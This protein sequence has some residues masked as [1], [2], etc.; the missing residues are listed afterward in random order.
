MEPGYTLNLI[1]LGSNTITGM[2]NMKSG[3]AGIFVQTGAT[4][5][6]YEDE[7]RG[8]LTVTGGKRG[9]AIGSVYNSVPGI[10]NIYGGTI[11][12]QGGVDGGAGIGSGRSCSGNKINIYG[13]N[14][15][16]FGGFSAAGIGSGYGTSGG[17]EGKVGDYNG[18]IINITG[19]TV[20][21]CSSKL[22]EGLSLDAFDAD[23]PDSWAAIFQSNGFSAGIGGGYG[24]SSGVITIG[25]D[26][27]VLAIG[28]CGGAG[29]GAGRGTNK[30]KN[31]SENCTPFNITIRDNAWVTAY[32]PGEYR[33]SISPGSGAGIGAGR[34]WNDG[35]SIVIE[36]TPVIRAKAEQKAA[37]I[38][39][40]YIV[41]SV[42]ET[43]PVAHPETLNIGPAAT[44]FAFCDGYTD[45]IYRGKSV[46]DD[47]LVQVS[48]TDRSI[49]GA[50]L[51]QSLL[52][53]TVL[54]TIGDMSVPKET[55]TKIP[56]T[57]AHA[58]A[59][60]VQLPGV[61]QY[62]FTDG[63]CLLTN[64]TQDPSHVFPGLGKY[65]LAGAIPAEYAVTYHLDGGTNHADNP[66]TYRVIGSRIILKD[67]EKEKCDF[68]GWFGNEACDGT[69][70]TG[71][72]SG[73]VGDTELWA[74]WEN[75]SYTVTGTEGTE[76]TIGS[77]KDAV[78]TVKRSSEAKASTLEYFT[79]A[80]M[81][82][83]VIPKKGYKTASGSL[84]M[85]LYSNYLDT[86]DEGDHT[87]T[88]RF[89]DGEAETGV[90]ILKAE[91]PTPTP[92]PT[93]A[94]SDTPGPTDTP[95]PVPKTGDSS[96][97]FLWFLLISL[98][99]AGLAVTAMRRR[100]G[101]KD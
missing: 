100:S 25:G 43:T 40:G 26:A 48:I 37:A 1:L 87:L 75:V 50:G 36:G 68:A 79:E 74:K 31:Y 61:E 66:E 29:I 62:C 81:D 78:V 60:A 90:T 47:T 91:T 93:P 67:P 20:R 83:T 17:G 35:G 58:N 85:T 13:G 46:S 19:G 6:I 2:S 73:S 88:I 70:V 49:S 82:G 71:I 14:I 51:P 10:I 5:N 97:P 95:K 76:H 63:T 55:N 56:V 57:A 38:G 28:S 23:D 8:S 27:Q 32:A 64:A 24:A 12:A 39:G 98:G 41:T 30:G 59:F 94:P 33:E 7:A 44:V 84:V 89:T 86:L 11:F 15:T 54:Y 92:T 96:D 22:Q 3:G 52:E 101:K 42:T 45:P 80:A 72:P 65:E 18:G 77:G 99:A 21:A 69:P 4:L 34:G 9:A 53:G 16:A